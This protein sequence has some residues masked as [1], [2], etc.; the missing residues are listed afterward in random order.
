MPWVILSGAQCCYTCFVFLFALL[1]TW[2]PFIKTLAQGQQMKNSHF[3]NLAFYSLITVCLL[4]CI[5]NS[6]KLNLTDIAAERKYQ[7]S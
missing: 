6:C 2:R 5:N 4:N 1:Y 3:A 7:L